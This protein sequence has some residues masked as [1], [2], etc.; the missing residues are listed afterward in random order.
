MSCRNV[1]VRGAVSPHWP[2]GVVVQDTDLVHFA[3][4]V[5]TF[6]KPGEGAV[7]GAQKKTQPC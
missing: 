1:Y 6:H 4:A 2:D 3:T 5:G 7:G